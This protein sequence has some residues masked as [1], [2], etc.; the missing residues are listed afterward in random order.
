MHP[1]VRAAFVHFTARFEGR[2]TFMYGDVKNLV[3]TGVGNL[4]DST[5][6]PQP[7]TP[8][9]KLPWK[10]L[11][12]TLATQM[13]VIGA[14]QAVKARHDL[15][16]QGGGHYAGVTTLRLSDADVD[17]LVLAK[18]DSN[19]AQLQRLLPGWDSM[20]ADAQL[21]LHSWA[22]A[23]GAA[24]RYP[25]MFA[26]LK[27]GDYAGASAECDINPKV[28]TIVL[29]NAANHA[30]LENAAQ[31]AEQGVDPSVLYYTEAQ[32]RLSLPSSA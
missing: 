23:V 28:G 17:A 18:L 22:W 19:E 9:L 21:A 11:D 10:R 4:I 16:Q 12:G 7:W 8:A 24:A 14:W 1:S 32:P 6:Q 13:D 20:P 2:L 5:P 30:L 25:S 31:V 15:T 29:R 27:R 26:A 3:T